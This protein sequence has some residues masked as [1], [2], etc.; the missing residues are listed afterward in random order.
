MK[1]SKFA[2]RVSIAV[3]APFLTACA[4]MFV[5]E[6]EAVIFEREI[7][8]VRVLGA[9]VSSGVGIGTPGKQVAIGGSWQY[10]DRDAQGRAFDCEA[11]VRR[12]MTGGGPPPATLQETFSEG[13]P[14][15]PDLG[16]YT[17]PPPTGG[18]T[19]TGTTTGGG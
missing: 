19:G 14:D 16:G 2:P 6:G 12:I 17:P 11:T 7:F 5:D 9:A 18:G 8:E 15:V 1:K 3:A 13:G 4:G 10:C